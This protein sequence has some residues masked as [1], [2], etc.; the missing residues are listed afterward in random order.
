[1][2][3][4]F[5]ILFAYVVTS[6]C[7]PNVNS[8]KYTHAFIDSL[9]AK[10]GAYTTTV[11]EDTVPAASCPGMIY[12]FTLYNVKRA[13]DGVYEMNLTYIE[14]ED[15]VDKSFK[16]SGRWSV[17][18]GIPSDSTAIV[19]QFIDF[20]TTADAMNLLYNDSSLTFLTKDLELVKTS[21]NYT[22]P[23]KSEETVSKSIN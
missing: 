4:L 10:N 3:K 18:N 1:M 9:F 22:L 13:T 11:Y 14:A 5:F 21:L 16:S 15:G 8:D 12:K 17:V 6:S 2:K 20:D 23:I 7:A 19:Y